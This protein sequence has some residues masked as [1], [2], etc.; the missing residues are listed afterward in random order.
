VATVDRL[1]TEGGDRPGAGWLADGEVLLHI[2]LPK[3]GTTALQTCLRSSRT[4]LAR[5]G[6][7]YPDAVSSQLRWAP[8]HVPAANAPLGWPQ[9]A[10][11]SDAAAEM[12]AALL[13]EVRAHHGRVVVS[14]EN[15]TLASDDV[16][17]LIVEQLGGRRVRVMITVRPLHHLLPSFWQNEVRAG[18]QTPLREWLHLMA[19]GPEH[20][21]DAPFW[22][23]YDL[24]R[25]VGR[26]ARVVGA[27]RV[28]TVVV[29]ALRPTGVYADTEHL[30]GLAPGTLDPVRSGRTNRSLSWPEAELVRN[31]NLRARGEVTDSASGTYG[32]VSV[33]ETAVWHLLMRREPAP[34]EP[35]LVV[36][37][38][39]I[40]AFRQL[41]L[42]ALERVRP[43]GTHLVGDL[44]RL[45]PE[46]PDAAVTADAGRAGAHV[47]L[48]PCDTVPIDAVVVLTE[49]LMRAVAPPAPSPAR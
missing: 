25:V 45:V 5:H 37:H 20:L 2:G 11:A 43:I 34:D 40:G 12:W 9:P 6:V 15:I 38:D 4:E 23:L 7:L 3:T 27:D 31:L 26:W 22:I 35:R 39:M 42:D 10:A 30:I 48:T 18:L 32:P 33:G 36:P 46:A 49:D 47:G 17:A 44:D 19:A 28:A 24:P 29:D 16:A 8:N 13:D 14:A 21:G 1:E 41:A